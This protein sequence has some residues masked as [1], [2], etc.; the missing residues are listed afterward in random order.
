METKTDDTSAL[1]GRELTITRVF[2][3]PRRLV[4]K[5]WTQ[6][7]HFARWLGP[8]DFTTTFCQMDVRVGGTYRA[9]I[10]SPEG[11]NHW[12]Q[13]VYR[14]LVEPE[15]LVFTFA[16]EDEEGKPKHE[17]LVTVTFAE[18]D[19]KTKLTFHQAFFLS[20]EARDSHRSGWSECLD[21]LADY[22]VEASKQGAWK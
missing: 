21:R 12:M 14:E 11:K 13:G 22:L 16:W 20:V 1:R 3:A 2:D 10:R 19:G 17:T 15:R 18:H 7:E 9:C 4:F 5:V 8:K 6:P